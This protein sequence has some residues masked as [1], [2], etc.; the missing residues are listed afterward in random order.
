MEKK[1][2]DQKMNDA[3][4]LEVANNNITNLGEAFIFKIAVD[5]AFKTLNNESGMFEAVNVI[6]DYL[7]AGS[8]TDRQAISMKAKKVY[9]DFCGCEYKNRIDR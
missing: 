5:Y 6:D 1:E 8:K 7:N 4:R 2:F 3:Y 9:E